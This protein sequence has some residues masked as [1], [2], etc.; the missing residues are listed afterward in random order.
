LLSIT[1]GTGLSIT[2][3][4]ALP[5]GVLGTAYSQTLVAAG[6]TPP[7]SWSVASGS[8]PGG[9]TLNSGGTL[10]GTPQAGGTFNFTVQVA[11]SA[12][13][14]VTASLSL[15]ITAQALPL[16]AV[17]NLPDT[18]PP[19][20]QPSVGL[21]LAAAYS[22]PLSGQ[23]VL[24][25]APDAVA[26]ADDP[27]IQF[28]TGGRTAD[29]TI[30]ADAIAATFSVS[31][32]QL[33]TGSV[34][35]TITV[36]VQLQAGGIDVTPSPAPVHTVKIDR[37]APVI[38]SVKLVTTAGGFEVWI[39]GYAPSREITAATVQF[40]PAAGSNLSTTTFNLTMSGASQ[41][42]YQ[43]SASTPYG[44]QFTIIQPF[45]VQGGSNP[46]RSVSVTLANT[47]GT[48]NAVSASF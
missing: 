23:L 26:P 2:S 6:G 36:T 19:L 1:V 14:S 8:L 12:Q 38:R 30:P 17:T 48:S 37:S 40:T 35:G 29:F 24:S 9:L 7:Y 43:T 3:G 31:N 20:E 13:A 34:A 46:V 22:V 21:A 44:S 27:A 28:S 32:L 42:W 18:A 45:T 47:V 5:T 41:Q 25:F 33:Q 15:D 10:A 16:V 4:P 11:D 39:T